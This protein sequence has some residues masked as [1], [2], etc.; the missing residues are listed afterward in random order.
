[1]DQKLKNYSSGMQVRLAFSCAI[2][3]KSDILVLD[4]VLAVGDEAFQ[5]KCNNYFEQISKDKNQTIILVT[6]NMDAIRKYCNKAILINDGEIAMVG[7]PEDVANE[8]SLKNSEA[9]T[10]LGL[11]EEALPV[12]DLVVKM[13]NKKII[14]EKEKVEIRVSYTADKHIQTAIKLAIIDMNSNVIVFWTSSG[15][16][17]QEK[18]SASMLCD[19]SHINDGNFKVYVNIRNERG[20]ILCGLQETL[21]PRFLLRR[22]DYNDNHDKSP[23]ILFDQGEWTD[24]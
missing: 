13:V 22:T 7:N 11:R 23:A 6:H 8:Y 3:A 9:N 5:R 17:D 14:T 4:E 16:Y 1:M 18:V 20:G 12:K 19:L 2:R 10:I 24:K 15:L 21:S